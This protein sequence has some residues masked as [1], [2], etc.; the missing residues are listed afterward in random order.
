MLEIL[1]WVKSK[2]PFIWT[3]IEWFN[4]LLVKLFY[5]GKIKKA[6]KQSLPYT[7][8]HGYTYRVIEKTDIDGLV[9]L[10]ERQPEGFDQFF[11]PHR[12]DKKG[13][14]QTYRNKTFLML[15][16]FDG[17]KIIG[18]S[19]IRFFVNNKSFRGKMVDAAYQGQGI[20]KHM[21]TLMSDIA[22]G[23]GFRLFATISKH[24]V[25]S[26]ASSKSVNSIKII[27]ELEDDYCYIEYFPKSK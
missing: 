7:D 12:F 21:G 17:S 18:Y 5:G 2:L 16:T 14:L 20:A 23:A 15:G 9:E 11:K 6:I 1:K 4:G 3:I 26:M 13:F 24:N 19:F 10:M 22:F 25:K 8:E 27:K